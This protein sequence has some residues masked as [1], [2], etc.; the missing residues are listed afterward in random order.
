MQCRQQQHC[1]CSNASPHMAIGGGVAAAWVAAYLRQLA[2]RRLAANRRNWTW[3]VTCSATIGGG[4]LLEQQQ[5][6]YSCVNSSVSRSGSL[7]NE[8][9]QQQHYSADAC[10]E[11]LQQKKRAQVV[12]SSDQS[13]A[14]MVA[15]RCRV[16]FAGSSSSSSR[17][18]ACGSGRKAG[19]QLSW[20]TLVAD[21]SSSGRRS[22]LA[23]ASWRR[24]RRRQ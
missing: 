7:S 14:F 9:Q 17:W 8:Q 5:H 10:G 20:R 15:S 3:P 21:A 2:T 19:S 11:Y 6:R 1:S 4:G 13:A 23:A 22:L 16:A 24:Q 12:N 18:R